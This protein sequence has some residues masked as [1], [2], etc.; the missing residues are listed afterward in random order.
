MSPVQ[1]GN[2]HP[3]LVLFDIDGTLLTTDMAGVHAMAEVGKRL[4]GEAF[5]FNVN[6]AGML[7]HLIYEEATRVNQITNHTDH[8]EQFLTD[9]LMELEVQL[10]QR[11]AK[12]RPLPGM[13]EAV[14][15]LRERSLSQ[16]DVIV[17][18]LTGNYPQAVPIKLRAAGYEPSHFEIGAFSR[19][20]ATR[21]DLTAHA[22][23]QLEARIE[24]EPDP[25]RVIVI[26]DTPLDV[27]CAKVHGCIAFG[28]GTASYS[29]EEL[30]QAG[31]DIAV[32]DLSDATPLFERLV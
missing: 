6:T 4:F 20:K 26:G 29:A 5:E 19:P 25:Q 22:L 7:D 3:W 12:V 31:A 8:H 23:Q 18:L 2:P 30:R 9:Y 32:D 1:N 17:G 27:E 16:G 14:T 21:P 11:A 15:T 13:A 10:K 28:V 24:Q